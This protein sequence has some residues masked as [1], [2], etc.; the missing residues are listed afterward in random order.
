[1]INVPIALLTAWA[2][3]QAVPYEL[4]DSQEK[5]DYLGFSYV[6]LGTVLF[7]LSFNQVNSWGLSSPAFWAMLLVGAALI[8]LFLY[9]A[10]CTAI[11]RF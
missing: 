1:M 4:H 3:Y 6:I 8:V 10:V 2:V 5:L 7:L 11:I 9:V